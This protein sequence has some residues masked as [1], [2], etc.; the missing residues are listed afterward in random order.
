[1]ATFDPTQAKLR[2]IDP[3]TVEML[4]RMN[5]EEREA[6]IF[7]INLEPEQRANIE[8]LAELPERV[9]LELDRFGHMSPDQREAGYAV[10][11][12]IVNMRWLLRVGKAGL[13]ILVA[14]SGGLIAWTQI[15][16]FFGKI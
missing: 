7:F 15:L 2:E 3:R 4:Y 8:W 12:T 14:I 5:E 13:A 10:V 1:M 16:R 6:L 9:R 11:R